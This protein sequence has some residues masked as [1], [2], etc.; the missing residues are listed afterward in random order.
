MKKRIPSLLATMIASACIANKASLPI[1]QRNV[2]LA[3]QAMI[4]R[5]WKGGLA[6]CR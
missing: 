6:I 4:V 1:S 5:S 2:C 3:C